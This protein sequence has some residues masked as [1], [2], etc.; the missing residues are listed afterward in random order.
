MNSP[1][2]ILHRCW[3]I[4]FCIMWHKE[5]HSRIFKRRDT[6]SMLSREFMSIWELGC[7]GV[8]S[9]AL[10]LPWQLAASKTSDQWYRR[11][12]SL[13]FL[14]SRVPRKHSQPINKACHIPA[15]TLHLISMLCWN[16]WLFLLYVCIFRAPSLSCIL[17][18]QVYWIT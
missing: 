9:L 8:V 16:Q 12:S 7:E 3:W 18:C 15:R 2:F 1:L 14:L 10:F 17:N 13:S 5:S 6:S 11:P 4:I